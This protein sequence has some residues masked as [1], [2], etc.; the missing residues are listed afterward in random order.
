MQSAEHLRIQYD[1]MSKTVLVQK[2]V[3]SHVLI[4]RF[5]NRGSAEQAARRFAEKYWD[6]ETKQ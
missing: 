3:N 2:G 6:H 5:D 1:S 4:E